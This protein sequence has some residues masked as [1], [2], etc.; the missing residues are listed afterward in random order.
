MLNAEQQKTPVHSPNDAWTLPT[1]EFDWEG[2]ESECPSIL[3]KGNDRIKTPINVK[4]YS[5]GKD[6]QRFYDLL[7]GNDHIQIIPQVNTGEHHTG[8]IHNVTEKWAMIDIGYRESIYID[9][10]KESAQ[11]KKLIQPGK[12]FMVKIT[13]DKNERGFIVGSVTEGT[14]QA[15]F[16]ELHKA[17]ED[18]K[19]AYTGTVTQMIPNGGYIV[20]IQG[21]DCFMPGSL[22]GAN[23]LSNFE[24]IIGTDLYVVPVSFSVEK[25]TVVVSH[26]KYL[27]ALVPREIEQLKI[28]PAETEYSGTVT[29]SAKFGVFVEFNGC[30]TGMIHINDLNEEFA[31]RLSKGSIQ[32]GD[33]ISFKVKEV[34]S[35]KKIT[36]TQIDTVETANPWE[37]ISDKYKIPCQIQGTVKSIKDYGIF[38]TVEEGIVG[39]LHISEL[40]G[41][42]I[43]EI[44]KG[45]PITV[46]LTRIDES[47]RKLFLKL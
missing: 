41:I 7:M 23:K 17:I 5:R 9:L 1:G 14:R 25:G 15:V 3:K 12:E 46:T 30:L 8:T 35:E 32:P 34:I 43:D 13:S 10:E 31:T 42:S 26:R 33:E 22:A 24:S 40:D 21:I 29:G 16:A 11:F 47:T 45:D 19:T 38:V 37:N 28:N 36:L 4:V 18:G 20:N 2:Y 39:L 27:Q 44:K 6:A